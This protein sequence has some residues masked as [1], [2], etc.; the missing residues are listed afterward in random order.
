MPKIKRK[1]KIVKEISD[2]IPAL[3]PK[4]QMEGI[5]TPPQTPETFSHLQNQALNSLPKWRVKTI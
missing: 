3:G 5:P 1:R 2:K 4:A